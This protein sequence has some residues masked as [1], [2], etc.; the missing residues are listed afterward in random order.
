MEWS[1][2]GMGYGPVILFGSGE[3]ARQGRQAQEDVLRGLPMPARVA[4]VESPAGFQPNVDYV[5]GKLRQ[6]V[7]HNLQNFR[8]QVTIVPARGAGDPTVD[9]DD[10][11]VAAQLQDA[12]YIMA[13]PGSPTYTARTLAG[14]ATLRAIRERWADG[15]GLA[16]ASAA[17]IAFSAHLLPVYE[18]YKAGEEPAWRPGLDLL[19]P[20]GLDLAIVPHWNNREGGEHLDTSCCYM[21]VA[22]FG[23]L[24]RMLPP[25]ATILGIDEHTSCI[26]DPEEGTVR[27]R[28]QGELT[29]MTGEGCR[30]VPAGE[31]LPLA[32][33]RALARSA[34]LG[35]R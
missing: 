21:G 33:I 2:V 1:M 23:R 4:I 15:A 3:T 14:T 17:A 28:G 22:R 30:T 12:T 5:T 35:R 24:R 11:E 13:G 9:P 29:L 32:E 19:E 31:E 16:F 34:P 10:P 8:P 27:V 26:I 18:I 20:L 25:T 6:F 7:E